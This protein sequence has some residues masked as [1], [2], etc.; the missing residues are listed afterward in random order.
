MEEESKEIKDYMKVEDG[1]VHRKKYN[2]S[3]MKQWVKIPKAIWTLP[4][5]GKRFTCQTSSCMAYLMKDD[6]KGMV[7]NRTSKTLIP[8]DGVVKSDGVL[9]FGGRLEGGNAMH[10]WG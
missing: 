2:G 1:S 10:I 8:L 6:V 3:C 7:P 9:K 4:I 5:L